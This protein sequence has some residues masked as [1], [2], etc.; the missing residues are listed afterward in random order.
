MRLFLL[1]I[2]I[3]IALGVSGCGGG[4]GLSTPVPTEG[5]S[6]KITNP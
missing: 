6:D 3:I 1:T 4:S 2:G 5:P